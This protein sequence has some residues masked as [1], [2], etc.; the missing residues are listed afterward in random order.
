MRTLLGNPEDVARE[1]VTVLHKIVS[2]IHDHPMEEKYRKLKK[3]NATFSRKL[4]GLPGGLPALRALGFVENGDDLVRGR[5]LLLLLQCMV[6]GCLTL[7]LALRGWLRVQQTLHPSPELWPV[8]VAAKRKLDGFMARLNSAIPGSVPAAAPRAAA[9]PAPTTG[10][11]AVKVPLSFALVVLFHTPNFA[12]L[13]ML[14]PSR[15]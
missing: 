3:S 10:T 13:F 1:A 6:L 11:A 2:N 4:G 15:P 9:A 14:V 8:V 7:P 12:V 5:L